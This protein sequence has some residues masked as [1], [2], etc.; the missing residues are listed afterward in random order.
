MDF[1]YNN[2]NPRKS[3]K[4]EDFD[5]AKQSFVSFDFRAPKIL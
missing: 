5:A 2:D 4:I 3:V 1:F